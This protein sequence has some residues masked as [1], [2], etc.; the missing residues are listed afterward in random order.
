[1]RPGTLGLR[2]LFLCLG[3]SAA[4]LP[5]IG[6]AH[7]EV[8]PP[9]STAGE[10][11]R[12]GL[13]VPTEKPI[14]TVRVEVQFPSELR[15]LDFETLAGWRL[16]SQTDTSGRPLGAVWEDG[17]IPAG[18][19]AE[20]GLR[21]QNPDRE[22]E[23][24]WTVIQTYADGTE[25]QW[26]GPT[27]ADFPAAVSHVRQ[28]ALLSFGEMLASIAVVLSLIAT[29]VTALA[30]RARRRRPGNGSPLGSGGGLA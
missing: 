2:L 26:V 4:L 30:L 22:V 9:E 6:L 11:Q 13:R 12:Y 16:S 27:T 21:A 15:V 1:M 23:L 24:R 10:T 5:G 8:V 3:I 25:V 28:R 19:F 14:P 29:I 17:S 18:Q 20:F 7:V